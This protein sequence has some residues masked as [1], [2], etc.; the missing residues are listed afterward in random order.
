MRADGPE[1]SGAGSPNA[2]VVAA[3]ENV[4]LMELVDRQ[5]HA[6]DAERMPSLATRLDRLGRLRALT[7]EVA[8][9]AADAISADFG[10]RSW[11]VTQLADIGAVRDAI[12]H[13]RPRLG[14]WMRTRRVATPLALQPANSRITPQPL[15]VIGIVSPWNYPFQLSMVPAVAALAAGNRVMIKTSETT[16]RFSALLARAVARR[17]GPDEMVVVAGDAQVGRAFVALPFDHLL[18]TGSTA[19]G[20][21]VALAAARR[22]TPVTL[23]LGGKS[24]AILAADC[25]LDVAV[26]RLMIGKLV[27]SGQTCV[28]PDYLLVH[29]SLM[30]RLPEALRAATRALYPTIRDNPD[31]SS[32]VS[33]RHLARLLDL[34]ED[35]RHHGARIE[36]LHAEVAVS[37][38]KLPPFAVLDVDDRMR[39]MQEE[40]F[41]PLLPVVPYRNPDEAIAYVNARDRPLALY[42]FGRSG[43]ERDAVLARTV[44]GGATINDCLFHVAHAGL[45]FGGVGASGQGRYH[46]E[47]GFRAFSHEKPVLIQSR[48]TGTGLMA[49]PYGRA[50]DRVAAWMGIRPRDRSDDQA[51]S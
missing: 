20:R 40:V 11:H 31:Y 27:N 24:P 8:N 18:F 43:A 2:Q 16:P 36:P 47:Y 1:S 42:W 13:A 10:H 34:L 4:D 14:R 9:D 48:W 46:G 28:A 19:I 3:G 17:F 23:E 44:A 12:A 33:P 25:V 26:T 22:L 6:F 50:F 30:P 32:I 51:G 45:P 49:P 38:R 15:G 35:A 37:E 7:D 21:E 5:R 29:E 41:G 39:V